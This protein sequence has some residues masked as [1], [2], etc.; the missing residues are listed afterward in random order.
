MNNYDVIGLMSGTSLD[1][2]DI[3]FVRFAKKKKWDFEIVNSQSISYD[4]VLQKKLKNASTLSSL[5]LKI[6]DLEYGKW[7]GGQVKKFM[8]FH[9]IIPK[10][11]VSHGHTIFHQPQIGLTQ[12]IGD[13]YQI[14]LESGIKT[15]CDLRS[16]DISLGGQGAPLVPIGD[17]LLFSEY[18]LCLNLGG[19]SNISFD[20]HG[21]RIAYDICPVNTALNELA[22]RK[23]LE[24]D[25]GGEIA[26]S[27]KINNKII[28]LLNALK[29]YNQ[30]PPKSLGMEWVKDNI[31]PLLKN[32]DT[33][34][35]L[36]TFTHHIAFQITASIVEH[37]PF[38]RNKIP[39]MLVTGGGAK[40][41]FLMDLLKIQANNKWEI[42][43]P[44]EQIVDF[45]EAIIFAF[46]GVLRMLGHVNTL[47][48]V[49]G[50]K[51]D[52]SGGLI[53]DHLSGLN[54]T[55]EV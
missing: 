23:N 14:M 20:K 30:P 4:S 8:E 35:L 52:S 46:L 39:N 36:N 48:S 54:Q 32:D 19:F 6:L 22:S 50:A 3:V 17:K 16:L 12:Q 53:Y 34:N 49:T 13:G 29:Y 10:L 24:Y 33:A 55:R 51:F 45:K 7:I 1:G 25:P 47:K 18:D 37:F 5:D 38:C 26:K 41:T 15:I 43:I 31:F 21:K 2:L 40:N 27:G 44:E 42:F 11:V 28:Q 9:K